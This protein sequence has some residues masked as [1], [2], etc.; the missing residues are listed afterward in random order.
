VKFAQP[1]QVSK[2]SVDTTLHS[3]SVSLYCVSTQSAGLKI[4]QERAL[5]CILTFYFRHNRAEQRASGTT[6]LSEDALV[7]FSEDGMTVNSL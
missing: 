4:D 7:M 3:L 2:C 5:Q 6:M 1:R